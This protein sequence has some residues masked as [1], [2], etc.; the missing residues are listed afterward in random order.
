M[1]RLRTLIEG[2]IEER[3]S[4]VVY[5]ATS[6]P[7]LLRIIESDKF[8]LTSLRETGWEVDAK[9]ADE[10][11][12]RDY[13]V[14]SVARSLSSEFIRLDQNL[15]VIRL[16]G[17]KLNSNLKS[18]AFDYTHF[19]KRFTDINPGFDEME[20]RIIS[21]KPHITNFSKYITGIYLSPDY[22]RRKIG[23]DGILGAGYQM[24][25]IGVE[26]LFKRG[27]PI[28]MCKDSKTPSFSPKCRIESM[29][30]FAAITGEFSKGD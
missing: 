13:Y 7:K 20:D 18:T 15:M 19:A 11:N 4:D 16:D 25:L 5:H 3:V 6:Y 17:R 27:I 22:I 12:I 30:E 29:D 1:I 26:E 28:Y 9:W 23:R 8:Q 21:R 14:M 24:L 10:L 2:V